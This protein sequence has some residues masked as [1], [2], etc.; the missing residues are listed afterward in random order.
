MPA[1]VSRLFGA[2]PKVSC[3]CFSRAIPRHRD[4]ARRELV[5]RERPKAAVVADD[6]IDLA[7]L[8]ASEAPRLLRFFR[9]RMG[10]G[11]D[12]ADLVQESFLKLARSS[13]SPAIANPAGYL[14]RIA[15]NVLFDLARSQRRRSDLFSDE[16]AAALRAVV[17]PEQGSALEAEELMTSYRRAVDALPPRTR[18]VFLLH[19]VEGLTYKAIAEQLGIGART[20]EWHIAEALVRIRRALDDE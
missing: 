10:T 15:R 14:H 16:P 20:V 6:E 7:A 11:A 9:S 17:P 3:V 12:S 8:Y 19:R 18:E 13:R 4:S 1:G 2:A 5:A